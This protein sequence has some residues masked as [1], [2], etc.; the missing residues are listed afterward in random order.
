MSQ[1]TSEWLVKLAFL[2]LTVVV[3]TMDGAPSTITAHHARNPDVRPAR[4][5]NVD[6]VLAASGSS[7]DKPSLTTY[8]Q[9]QNGKY[10]IHVNIK[11]VKIIAVDGENLEGNLGDDTDYD[12][13]DYDY[14]P[15]H[16][17]VSPLPIFGSGSVSITKPPKSTTKAPATISSTTPTPTT[18]TTTTRKPMHSVTMMSSE[19]VTLPSKE[20]VKTPLKPT[21]SSSNAPEAIT[22]EALVVGGGTTELPSSNIIVIKPTPAPVQYDYQEIPVQ[23]IMD[24]ILRPGAKYRSS[25]Q[26]VPGPVASRRHYEAQPSIRRSINCHEGEY[27]DRD[28]NCRARRSGILKLFRLLS[29]LK[30]KND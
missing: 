18:T 1:F 29:S 25:N 7:N 26:H 14:D 6:D 4:K 11:D 21:E 16:L 8:D 12:Y 9:R 13:G 19:S 27:R 24:P 10:N 30:E 20:P 15:A 23:V 2:L 22:T 28:G 17:T 3:A 5:R